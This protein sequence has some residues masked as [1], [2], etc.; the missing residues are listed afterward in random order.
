VWL[1]AISV[2]VA[3]TTF[4]AGL[5]GAPRADAV[6][7]ETEALRTE[8][9]TGD[10]VFTG[11]GWGHGVGMSQWGAWQAAKEGVTFDKI[12][13]FYYP[14]TTLTAMPDPDAVLKVRLSANPPDSTAVNFI[15]VDLK[16]SV[17]GATLVKKASSGEQTEVF[18][19]GALMNVFNRDGKIVVVTGAGQ[20][21][22]F[23]YVD[24]RP[25]RAATDTGDGRVVVQMRTSGTLYDSREYWGIIRVQPGDDPGELWVYN[26]VAVD[27]YVRDI[28]EVDLDWAMPSASG[29]APE[30]V[31]AQAVAART[32]A[33]AKNGTLTDGW[34]DQYYGGYKLEVKA[35]GLAD[36]AEDTAGLIL[37]Y[38]GK[39]ASTYF[40]AHSGGYTTNTAWSGGTPPY[41]VSQPDPWSLKAPPYSASSAGPGWNWTYTIS[42]PSLSAKVNNNLKNLSTGKTF[43]IGLVGRI[44]IVDRDTADPTSHV[45]T[46]RLT[47][48]KGTAVV[49]ATSLKSCLGLR[50]TLILTV[51]GGEPLEAGEFYDVGAGHLYHDQIARMVTAGLMGGYEGGLF[52]PD[53]S[54]SRWQFA[55]ISVNLYNVM[56]PDA[57]IELVDVNTPPYADVP[58]KVGTL[59]DESDW[60]SAAKKAGLVRGVTSTSFQPYTILCRDEMAAMMCKALGWDDEAAALPATAVG[61]A[62]VPVGSEYWASATYLKK[63]G[64]LQGY[65][66]PSDSGA[67]IL[68][69]DEAIKRQH[70]AV[71]LCRV[72]DLAGH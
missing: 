28:G 54:I 21:G 71:I 8:A 14:G 70:V 42:P 46:L 43:D 34:Q 51:T 16:P 38:N 22:P 6:V 17:T 35:P 4:A 48:E 20:Q 5:A 24:L 37:T 3:L 67:V 30:A 44:E 25:T 18:P 47:G 11:R 32:Y 49:S 68:K 45:R 40:S 41:I 9:A 2:M 33:L 58:M 69:V 31:K 13:A 63:Q 59:G 7:G 65:P 64:I 27:K 1:I 23:D 53:G 12:L 26:F 62:D 52:K 56:H 39:P 61:F 50:S 19:A 36:G 60:V 66:D 57:R 55:K 72:L 10:F 15:Q 29:Y